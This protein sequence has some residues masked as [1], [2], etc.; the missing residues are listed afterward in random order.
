[1]YK[2]SLHKRV[3]IINEELNS[4]DVWTLFSFDFSLALY[5]EYMYLHIH[6]IST[7]T[8]HSHPL[9]ISFHVKIIIFQY[10]KRLTLKIVELIKSQVKGLFQVLSKKSAIFCL[11][12]MASLLQFEYLK[13]MQENMYL[14]YYFTDSL[15]HIL[16]HIFTSHLC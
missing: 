12:H 4:F 1:M 10:K 14:L 7:Y 6:S 2:Q 9:C 11:W 5:T 3:I 13:T 15:L 8:M 16:E